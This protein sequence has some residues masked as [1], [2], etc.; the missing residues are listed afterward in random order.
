M[1]FPLFFPALLLAAMLMTEGLHAQ[2]FVAKLVY[3]RNQ[4]P[5]EKSDPGLDPALLKKIEKTFGYKYHRIAAQARSPITKYT[6]DFPRLG[7]DFSLKIEELG[8]QDGKYRLR[9][10]LFHKNKSLL[11]T[12][13][14]FRKDV[15]LLIR[16]P[17]YDQGELILVIEMTDK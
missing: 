7:Q 17:F 16:G 14:D 3:A 6:A 15:P 12:T 11:E 1:K 4:P 13:V 5:Q 2:D 10:N 8:H 9:I